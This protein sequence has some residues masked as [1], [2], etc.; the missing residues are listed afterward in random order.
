MCL[1]A[2]KWT[3]IAAERWEEKRKKE[4]IEN[5]IYLVAASK[6]GSSLRS[7]NN[8]T[9]SIEST[10]AKEHFQ[11]CSLLH[12]AKC[13]N[14][15]ELRILVKI[16]NRLRAVWIPTLWISE[17]LLH[18]STPTVFFRH[19]QNIFLSHFQIGFF[20]PSLFQFHLFYL[21]F[22]AI[23][24]LYSSPS[25]L[26]LTLSGGSHTIRLHFYIYIFSDSRAWKFAKI[27]CIPFSCWFDMFYSRFHFDILYGLH[28]MFK[29]KFMCRH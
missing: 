26:S 13:F 6:F 25:P 9:N 7:S 4:R 15:N 23:F 1:F 2:I 17:P 8:I 19:F 22:V 24:Q 5:E 18:T 16:V 3:E 12:N 20:C 27:T 10:S 29:V 11:S 14:R 28:A 21:M